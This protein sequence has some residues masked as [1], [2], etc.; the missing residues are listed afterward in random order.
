MNEESTWEALQRELRKPAEAEMEVVE[1]LRAVPEHQREE[2][3][4]EIKTEW[5]GDAVE[6]IESRLQD[7]MNR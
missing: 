7:I 4:A 2:M 5:G 6:R 3:L 1:L